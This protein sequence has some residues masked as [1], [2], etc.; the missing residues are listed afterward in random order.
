M[1]LCPRVARA[2]PRDHAREKTHKRMGFARRVYFA[3][4]RP[5]PCVIDTASALS[6]NNTGDQ[7]APGP[8]KRAP[9]YEAAPG[10]L[11][12]AFASGGLLRLGPG[13]CSSSG[14]QTQEDYNAEQAISRSSCGHEA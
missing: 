14:S 1:S 4:P 7:H 5:Y 11:G 10:P 2:P 3:S 12:A 8:V 6:R 13:A 9:P